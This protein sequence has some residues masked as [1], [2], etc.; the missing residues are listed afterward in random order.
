MEFENEAPGARA[1]PPRPVLISIVGF[2]LFYFAIVT[3]RALVLWPGDQIEMMW[4][5]AAVA[6]ASMAVTWIF[7]RLLRPWQDRGLRQA[8]SAAALLAIPAAIIY[9]AVNWYAFDD[10]DQKHKQEHKVTKVVVRS[11]PH[12]PTRPEFSDTDTESNAVPE[13]PAPPEPPQVTM[14]QVGSPHSDDEQMTPVQAIADN[15]A[16]GYFFFIAWAALYLALCYAAEAQMLERR[17][18]QLRGAAQAAELRALRYQVNPH[19]LFNT[20]NSLSSLVMTGKREEAERM[21]LNLSNFFRTSLSGDPTE[22]V[23]LSAEIQLQ[24]LYLDIEGVRFPDRLLVKVD[25]P[26]RLR[27]ACVPGLLLQPLVENAVKYGVARNRRPVTI[28]LSAFEDS[29]GL[30]LTV[31]NDGEPGDVRAEEQG[32]GVGLANVRDRLAARFGD[33]A[34]C[35]WGP[36]PGGGFRVTLTMPIHGC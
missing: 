21:I 25:L 8:A 15:S 30:V 20:L 11:A 5:R 4:R 26:E 16:N 3:L 29:G 2:W 7:Y 23:P 36:L 31:E 22:D 34:S 24:R 10:I 12:R 19:F 17:T 6:L 35:R 13:P 14:I 32:T 1:L 9:S 18:A 33:R 27:N 28:A